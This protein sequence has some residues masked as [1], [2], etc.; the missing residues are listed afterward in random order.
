MAIPLLLKELP[1]HYNSL[2]ERRGTE[3][4]RLSHLE[5]EVFGWDHPQAAKHCVATGGLYRGGICELD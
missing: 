2:V 4:V 1:D 3:R 5:R